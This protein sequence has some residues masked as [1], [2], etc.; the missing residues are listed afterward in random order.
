MI[1]GDEKTFKQ[2]INMIYAI[3]YILKKVLE[4]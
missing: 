2:P 3:N 4:Y 1:R